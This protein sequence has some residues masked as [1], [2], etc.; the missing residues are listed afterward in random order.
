MC[1]IAVIKSQSLGLSCISGDKTAT[2]IVFSRLFFCPYN[3]SMYAILSFLLM[4]NRSERIRCTDL[5]A[6]NYGPYASG[7]AAREPIES[8]NNGLLYCEIPDSCG[9]RILKVDNG[10]IS[11]S[12][13][14][15]CP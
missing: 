14:D 1:A 7:H 3:R 4:E 8:S 11:S 13:Y 2:D 6:F 15:N 12:Y 10:L 5:S 9:K